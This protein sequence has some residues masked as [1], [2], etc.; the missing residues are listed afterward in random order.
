LKKRDECCVITGSTT[1]EAAHII[2]HAFFRNYYHLWIQ[3]YQQFCFIQEHGIDDVRNGVLLSPNLHTQ[4]DQYLFT[5]VYENNKYR[6]KKSSLFPI[7]DLE[8]KEI[9]FKGDASL[10]PSAGFLAF[11]NGQF[12]AKALRASA[13]AESFSSPNCSD[14]ITH[15]FEALD[16]IKKKWIENQSLAAAPQEDQQ[17]SPMKEFC[18]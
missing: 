15:H 18:I 9:Q 8:E 7:A 4:F 17:L 10:F 3:L 13:E 5:I 1:F 11:H 14:T 16:E 2:P 6:I 12:E